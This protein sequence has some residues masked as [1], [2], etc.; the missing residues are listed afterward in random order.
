MAWP[1]RLYAA[2]RK[3]V[4]NKNAFPFRAMGKL[5]FTGSW[6]SATNFGEDSSA[7]YQ[8]KEGIYEKK[9]SDTSYGSLWE[10]S[11]VLKEF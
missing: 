10:V 5:F 7:I 2:D 3:E 1:R 11:F 9:C 4:K 8:R 6:L